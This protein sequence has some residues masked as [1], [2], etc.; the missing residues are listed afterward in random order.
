MSKN[1]EILTLVLWYLCVGASFI[2]GK[3]LLLR[4][5]FNYNLRKDLEEL[6]FIV[7]IPNIKLLQ[8]VLLGWVTEFPW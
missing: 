7:K 1:F 3:I 5:Q 2:A 6:N 4:V 8:C